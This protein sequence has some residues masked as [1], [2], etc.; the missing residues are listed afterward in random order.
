[1]AMNDHFSNIPG[2]REA[3]ARSCDNCEGQTNDDHKVEMIDHM[4]LEN[5]VQYTRL[6]YKSKKEP[7]NVSEEEI[8][9]DSRH[10]DDGWLHHVMFR[11]PQ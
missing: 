3:Y 9:N 1:M 6:R 2:R 11:G 7:V 10:Y 8:V 4:E 5:E